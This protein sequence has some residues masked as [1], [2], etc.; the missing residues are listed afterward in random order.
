MGKIYLEK[1]VLD[2]FFERMEYVFDNFDNVYFSVSGGKDSSVMVQL[3]NIVA[4]KK[5]KKYDVLFMDFEAQYSLTMQHIEELKQLSMIRKFYHCCLE[6]NED[7]GV[8]MFDPEWI[9]WDHTKKELWVREMPTGAEIINRDNCP[10][11]FYFDGMEDF[12]FTKLFSKWYQEQHGGTVAVGVGIRS[13]ES[14][15]RFRTIAQSK[16]ETFKNLNW[17]TKICDNVYNF[18]PMY[19]WRTEDVWGAVAK[20]DLMFNEVYELMYKNG[21]SIHEQRLCQPF[22][23]DQRQGLDQ[24]KAIEPETWEKLLNR[25]SGANMG[26]LYCRTK[27]LGHLGTCKPKHM[28]WEEY[29]MFLLESIGL[30][31]PEIMKHYSEKIERTLYWHNVKKGN[32]VTDDDIEGTKG[33][34]DYCS[35]RLIAKAIEKND[36][37][38]KSLYFAETKKGYEYLRQI[39]EKYNKI[40]DLVDIDEKVTK[41]RGKLYGENSENAE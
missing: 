7:N 17:T 2:A 12:D 3:A 28:T 29:S 33:N 30:Y 21:L 5:N 24:F 20:Y 37:W 41:A 39:Q 11:D 38:F 34:A 9:T 35:W 1:N 27:L 14:L 26:S 16:K 19:D 18:Y 22:G 36:F 31:S 8:S 32:P 13:D 4:K 25:V 10:F 6:W 40:M 23:L 15:N